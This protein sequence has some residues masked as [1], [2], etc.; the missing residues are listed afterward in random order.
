VVR[1]KIPFPFGGF[2]DGACILQ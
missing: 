1:N 2:A